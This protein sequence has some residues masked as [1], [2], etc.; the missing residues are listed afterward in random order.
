MSNED[1]VKLQ[2]ILDATSNPNTTDCIQLTRAIADLSSRTDYTLLSI[3]TPMDLIIDDRC[4]NWVFDMVLTHPKIVLHRS[5]NVYDPLRYLCS[6]RKYYPCI[7][8]PYHK[9]RTLLKL[10][11]YKTT[12]AKG[13]LL[14]ELVKLYISYKF[15]VHLDSVS[16]NNHFWS[17]VGILFENPYIWIPSY[18]ALN[19][20]PPY[21]TQQANLSAVVQD[22][23]S[24][25]TNLKVLILCIWKYGDHPIRVLPRDI[26]KII[27]GL[28][29]Y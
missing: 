6:Y 28:I 13:D 1:K 22:W 9:I 29:F 16:Y 18:D 7:Y 25:R 19:L 24:K 26:I 3:Y 8:A 17:I 21:N 11:M 4:P 14:T 2:S 5:D 12:D 23:K 15:G 27:I 10:G 20:P